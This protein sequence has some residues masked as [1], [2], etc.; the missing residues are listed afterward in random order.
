MKEK[1]H[2]SDDTQNIIIISSSNIVVITIIVIIICLC[3]S[4]FFFWATATE[5]NFWRTTKNVHLE[6]MYTSLWCVPEAVERD[7]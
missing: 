1:D 4:Q 5:F 3:L 2:L 6:N 7:I